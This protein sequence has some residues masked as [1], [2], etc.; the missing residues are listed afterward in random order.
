MAKR[1]KRLKKQIEGFEKQIEKHRNKL[2]NEK[3]NKDTTH[4]YWKGEIER[5]RVERGKREEIL[6]KL[7]EKYKKKS[8]GA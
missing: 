2:E 1:K 7:E 6:K 5:F 3:G 4:D 8:G